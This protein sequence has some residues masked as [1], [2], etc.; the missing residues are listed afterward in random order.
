LVYRSCYLSG[1]CEA[2]YIDSSFRHKQCLCHWH[3]HGNQ[4]CPSIFRTT[5]SNILSFPSGASI[6]YDSACCSFFSMTLPSSIY[7]APVSDKYPIPTSHAF[8]G[9]LPVPDGTIVSPF[10]SCFWKSPVSF[11]MCTTIT[12]D[13]AVWAELLF[14]G[15]NLHAIVCLKF[16]WHN[17][18]FPKHFLKTSRAHIG[19]L[20][21]LRKPLTL[22]K[23]LP[24]QC[25]LNSF[26]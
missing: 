10:R 26:P 12:D 8:L 5:G 17:R 22:L 23:T 2:C 18:T 21:H 6:C 16:H 3:D 19:F 25:F 20:K 13:H 9:L 7:L 15:E 14:L 1:C 4:N 24:Y 11:I